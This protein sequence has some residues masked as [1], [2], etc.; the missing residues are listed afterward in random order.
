MTNLSG[1]PVS[2]VMCHASHDMRHPP[3]LVRPFNEQ[4][5]SEDYF[6]V[7]NLHSICVDWL[8]LMGETAGSAG[9]SAMSDR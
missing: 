7:R 4:R 2:I 1:R 8:S 3:S 9:R 5:L 6:Q